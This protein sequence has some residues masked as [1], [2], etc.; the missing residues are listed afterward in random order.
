MSSM[1]SAKN[2]NKEFTDGRGTFRAVDDFSY[3]FGDCGFYF[4]LGKSGSGKSTLLS[5]L[6]GLEKPTSGSL[7]VRSGLRKS[8]VFQDE[9]FIFSLSLLDNL[10]LIEPDE[11]AIDRA[12]SS[13][14]MLEKKA[15]SISLLSKG[16]RARLAIAKALLSRADVIFLDEPTGNLDG[17]NAKNV[18]DLLG[19]LSRSILVLCVSHDEESA[20]RYAD[21]I[22]RIQDGKLVKEEK[23]RDLPAKA[24]QSDPEQAPASSGIPLGIALKYAGKKVGPRK[25][26]FW[27]S[28]INLT[29][30]GGLV[31]CALGLL[32]LDRGNTVRQAVG[33]VDIDAYAVCE[34]K[35][36]GGVTFQGRSAGRAFETELEGLG[37][38]PRLGF[39]SSG[40]FYPYG[41]E[42]KELGIP[43]PQDGEAVVSDFLLASGSKK[44]GEKF[45]INGVP[46]TV[47]SSFP[48]GYER[49]GDW[50]KQETPIYDN[51]A[52][53]YVSAA[54]FERL[55]LSGAVY[56]EGA[57]DGIATTTNWGGSALTMSEASSEKILSGETPSFSGEVLASRALASD[58][59]GS[60]DFA[61]VVGKSYKSAEKQTGNIDFA[62]KVPGIRITGVFDGGSDGPAL[63]CTPGLW[64]ALKEERKTGSVGCALYVPKGEMPLLSAGIHD[65]TLRF[66]TYSDNLLLQ[67]GF[68][69]QI[70]D[71]FKK[72]FAIASA[73][74]LTLGFSFLL[75]YCSDN[76]RSSEKDI[77]LLKLSGKKDAS[78]NGMFFLANSAV[79]FIS[80]ALA[81]AVGYSGLLGVGET[82]KNSY[83]LAFNPVSSS[84][85]AYLIVAFLF[86]TIPFALSLISAKRIRSYDIATIFKRNLV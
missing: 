57:F 54:T 9:N 42:E 86:L 78:V 48:S 1:I 51:C 44:I 80:L 35:A 12:L 47:G 40:R 79:V 24:G 29:L 27:M 31:F 70:A 59:A 15:T 39:A 43:D 65:Q 36:K 22:L 41:D 30:T 32:F 85:W 56:V 2:V 83:S 45:E 8:F 77:A 5:L 17:A 7:S 52:Y 81:Y 13:V 82:V 68:I 74:F 38:H 49:Y 67:V 14:G 37:V 50:K 75:S 25:L 71:T 28:L 3:S 18:L 23:K 6:G 76:L 69:Y 73:V 34:V 16:E 62:S 63:L 10:R 4:I 11:K 26:K 60:A 58:L 64:D 72:V 55:A 19:K 53:S 46:L 33:S 84:P 20:E 66:S 21:V 61:T